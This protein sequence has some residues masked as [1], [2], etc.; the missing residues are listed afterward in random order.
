MGLPIRGIA[1]AERMPDVVVFHAGTSFDG[2][3]KT[4]GGRVLGVTAIG[5]TLR[6]ALDRAY[7]AT[8]LIEFEGKQ[9][10]SDI[11]AK[12]LVTVS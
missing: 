11:G 9:Y 5:N 8:R 7:E 2:E 3:L 10:R 1:E 4:S 12:A 6:D